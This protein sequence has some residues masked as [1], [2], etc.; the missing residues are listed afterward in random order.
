MTLTCGDYPATVFWLR[1]RENGQGF[2]YTGSYSKSKREGKVNKDMKDRFVVKE[3][4]LEVTNFQQQQDSGTYSCLYINNNELK[5]SAITELRGETSELL[6]I[7]I[8][9]RTSLEHHK[10]QRFQIPK[11]TL[12]KLVHHHDKIIY[13]ILYVYIYFLTALLLL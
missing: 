4:T 9:L 8:Q 11:Y 10:N 2:E 6:H 13:Y 7:C 12:V 3:K 5:F 1:L